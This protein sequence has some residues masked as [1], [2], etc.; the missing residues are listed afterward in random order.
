MHD[1]FECNFEQL[2]HSAVL[3]HFQM[4]STFLCHFLR[5]LRYKRSSSCELMDTY[6]IKIMI[7]VKNMMVVGDCNN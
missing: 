1:F 7:S 2:T 6:T 5:F 3:F 4:F